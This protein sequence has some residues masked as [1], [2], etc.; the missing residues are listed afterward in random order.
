MIGSSLS[1]KRRSGQMYQLKLEPR[2]EETSETLLR[3]SIEASHHRD[4]ERFLALA[5]VALGK[6]ATEV[7][8]LLGRN[9][10]T[11]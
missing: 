8:Q 9:P 3:R 5:L 6:P 10:Q 7:A 2:W 1:L 4:R 11:V